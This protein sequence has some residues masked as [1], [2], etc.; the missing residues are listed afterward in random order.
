MSRSAALAATLALGACF[1]D[2]ADPITG[3][4]GGAGGA[5]GDG[6]AGGI[7]ADWWDPAFRRRST[8]TL[9]DAPSLSN[10]PL[11]V[12]LDATRIDYA[13][14]A[15]DGRDL[16]FVVEATEL[17]YE[18]ERWD[19]SGGSLVWV[20]LPALSDGARIDMYYGHPAATA[21]ARAAEVWTD[22]TA[23]YHFAQPPD[24]GSVVQDSAGAHDGSADNFASSALVDG[25]LGPAYGFD[26]TRYVT[27]GF[28]G[29]LDIAGR[30]SLEVVV[31]L[32]GPSGRGVIA[33]KEGCCLGWLLDVTAGGGLRQSWGTTDCC[34]GGPTYDYVFWDPP[35]PLAGPWRHLVAVWDV[36]AG[37]GTLFVDGLQVVQAGLSAGAPADG[38]FRIGADYMGDNALVATLEE[39]R[40][41]A[42]AYDAT[43]VEVHDRVRRDAL[44]HYGTI[45]SLP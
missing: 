12:V 39:L 5:G 4:S 20:L 43:R 38:T 17:P 7:P 8:L 42:T 14:A 27:V 44:I 26:G 13:A 25:P 11:A 21:P 29:A 6:E 36:D 35:V 18:I 19:P 28:D 10:V 40:L 23:V 31:R 41:S 15:A 32:D 24:A 22:Y 30:G 45:E 34:S 9:D 1:F 3:T 16:R 37:L 33:Q 2:L